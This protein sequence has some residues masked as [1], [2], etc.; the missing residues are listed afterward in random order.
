MNGLIPLNL[1]TTIG[2][3]NANIGGQSVSVNPMMTASCTCCNQHRYVVCYQYHDI[4]GSI[5][6]NTTKAKKRKV[7]NKNSKTLQRTPEARF[8]EK[9][10]KTDNCWEWTAYKLFNGYGR[11]SINSKTDYAHRISWQFA[12][13]EYPTGK[14]VL[15]TCDNSGCVNPNHLF[16][17]TLGDNMADRNKK[18]RQYTSQ[19][20]TCRHGYRLDYNGTKRRTAWECKACSTARRYRNNID[21][22]H[23]SLKAKEYHKTVRAKKKLRASLQDD[24]NRVL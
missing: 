1:R 17:G 8:W 11:F 20:A 2:L 9:V 6:K 14:Q 18:N 24:N 3:T 21:P 5:M 4:L 22:A 16:L 19:K 13:G 7:K 23:R 12:N 10:N 15:H